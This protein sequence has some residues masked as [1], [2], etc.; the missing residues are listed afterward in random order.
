M[1]NAQS[2]VSEAVDRFGLSTVAEKLGVEPKTVRR[3][4][5]GE[6]SP[7]P[8]LGDAVRQ[9]LLPLPL[10]PPKA[11]GDFTFIDLFAGIGGMRTAFE[12]SGGALRLYQ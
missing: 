12:A 6:T 11:M 7:P 3:W 9:R 2:L 5:V 1:F 8:Y 10:E 4:I